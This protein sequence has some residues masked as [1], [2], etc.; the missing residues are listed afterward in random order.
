VYVCV[1][2]YVCVCAIVNRVLIIIKYMRYQL[3]D[4]LAYGYVVLRSAVLFTNFHHVGVRRAAEEAGAC[5]C[6]STTDQ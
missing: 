5:R 2:L 3:Q 1:C 6:G 4:K